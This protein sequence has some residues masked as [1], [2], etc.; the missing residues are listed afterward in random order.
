MPTYEYRCHIHGDIEIVHS[1]KELIENCP[2]C[3]KENVKTPI[4]RMISKSNGFILIGGG[5]AADNYK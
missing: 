3:E 2:I 4:K 5:W 1:I